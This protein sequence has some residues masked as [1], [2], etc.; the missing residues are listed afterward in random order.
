MKLTAARELAAFADGRQQAVED[1]VG[2]QRSRSGLRSITA[3][4][5]N[6]RSFQQILCGRSSN[7][8]KEEVGVTKRL[9]VAFLVALTGTLVL[10]AVGSAGSSKQSVT[11]L[12][13]SSCSP[14]VYKGSGS[15]NAI[16]SLPTSRFRV[17]VGRRRLR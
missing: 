8:P 14:L 17:R 2:I 15:P 3:S 6:A 1:R 16:L 9:F 5:L 4:H 11:P 10:A 13:A 7:D 12:P